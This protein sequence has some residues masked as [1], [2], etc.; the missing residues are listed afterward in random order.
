MMAVST[1]RVR[2]D[3]PDEMKR[4]G[5]IGLCAVALGFS[6]I[7]GYLV[8]REKVSKQPA[9]IKVAGLRLSARNKNDQPPGTPAG[10]FVSSS[11]FTRGVWVTCGDVI[12]V[13][14]YGKNFGLP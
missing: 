4:P 3:R 9:V 6:F 2:C 5:K 12:F 14:S 10:T 1:V 8:V 13:V 11:K 7:V